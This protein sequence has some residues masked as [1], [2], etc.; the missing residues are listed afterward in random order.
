MQSMVLIEF[1]ALWPTESSESDDLLEDHGITIDKDDQELEYETGL[2][3]INLFSIKAYYKNSE[4]TTYI[5]IGSEQPF[6]V[7]LS[8]DELTQLFKDIHE[9]NMQDMSKEPGIN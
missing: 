5:D 1:T 4:E 9:E 6:L 8:Y 2:I 7:Y 3:S